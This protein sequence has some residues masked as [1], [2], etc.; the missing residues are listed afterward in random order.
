MVFMYCA[1]VAYLLTGFSLLWVR[2]INREKYPLVK[3]FLSVKNDWYII[4]GLGFPIA[5]IH[6]ILGVISLTGS[7]RGYSAL[8]SVLLLCSLFAL[9]ICF[10]KVQKNK[11]LIKRNVSFEELENA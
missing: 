8:I 5:S 6:V 2:S 3:D 1:I 4:I 7:L 9:R 11:K 10:L